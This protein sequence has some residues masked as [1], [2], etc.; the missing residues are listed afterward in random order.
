[1]RY[2]AVCI[3]SVQLT[4]RTLGSHRRDHH[5]FFLCPPAQKKEEKSLLVGIIVVRAQLVIVPL[6]PILRG[7]VPKVLVFGFNLPCSFSLFFRLSF[8]LSF[9]L[10][11]LVVLSLTVCGCVSAA[12]SRFFLLL[13]VVWLIRS[14]E[15][16]V[17]RQA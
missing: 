11:Y 17:R 6:L 10:L 14:G 9:T 3:F 13:L 1:M 2:T 16:R 8:R 12:R 7:T 15:D 4:R 5:R